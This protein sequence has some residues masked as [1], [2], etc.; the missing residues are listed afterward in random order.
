MDIKTTQEIAG[1]GSHV[2]LHELAHT[3]QKNEGAEFTSE[4]ANIY[5]HAKQDGFVDKM[6]LLLRSVID[7]HIGTIEKTR[8]NYEN[9]RTTN[10]A[11]SLKEQQGN[12]IQRGSQGVPDRNLLGNEGPVPAG[13]SAEGEPSDGG[14]D[15][16][17]P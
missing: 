16:S 2:I 8:A 12:Q 13:G 7:K 6:K 14:K 4:L 1:Y 17:A 5:G 9:S 3:T 11:K 15:T 10:L